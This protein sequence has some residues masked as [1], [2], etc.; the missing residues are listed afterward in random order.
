LLAGSL[1]AATAIVFAMSL[2]WGFD[3][4]H[5]RIGFPTV[6]RCSFEW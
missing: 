3:H 6:I 2:A 4:D 5:C 1:A